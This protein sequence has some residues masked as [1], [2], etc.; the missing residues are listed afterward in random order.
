MR[1]ERCEIERETTARVNG[2]YEESLRPKSVCGVKKNITTSLNTID[3]DVSPKQN[4]KKLHVFYSYIRKKEST[5]LN[6]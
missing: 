2:R 6:Y 3:Y 5:H 1:F 4:I